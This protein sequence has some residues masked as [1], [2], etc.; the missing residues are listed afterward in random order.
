MTAV[1]LG[2]TSGLHSMKGGFVARLQPGAMLGEYVVG[3]ALWQLR[4][5]EAYRGN[6][7]KG[8][9]TI[10]VIHPQYAA[11]ATIRAHIVAGTRAAA[12]LP[13]HKHLVKTL[14]AG[15]TGDILWI[16]TEEVDGSLVRDL[17]AKKRSA[18]TSGFGAR[19]T[20]NLIAGVSAALAD[21]PHGALSTE[22]VA[23][24]RSGRVRVLDLA[25]AQGT[26]AAILTGAMPVTQH[27]YIAPEILAGGTPDGRADVYGIG[28]LLYEAL[29]GRPFEKG[30]P[31]PSEAVPNLSTQIDEIMLRSCIKDPEKRFS[32]TDVLGEVVSEALTKGG[33][34]QTSMVPKVLEESVPLEAQVSSLAAEI[35]TQS[36]AP[37]AS[38]N[39]VVDRALAAALADGAE[40]W[41][42][43]KGKMDYGP[44]SLAD[45]VKQIN[46]GDIV[47]GNIIVDK[48]D[49]ARVAVDKH[50]LL[51]PLV[52]TAKQK[53]D[54]ARRAQAEVVEQSRAK[55]RGATLYIVI[56]LVVAAVAVG[57]VLIVKNVSKEE[58][59]KI[60]TVTA[61]D[62]AQLEVKI[63]VPKAPPKKQRTAGGGGTAGGGHATS[64]GGG[65]KNSSDALALDMS[66][67]DEDSSATLDMTTVYRVYSGSANALAQCLAN[68]GGGAASIEIIINGPTGRVNFVRVN[69][70]TGGGLQGCIGGVMA[71]LQFPK[72]SGGRTRAEFDMAI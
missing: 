37:T 69:G 59:V 35:G 62:G 23:V 1:D 11:D 6:G 61:S 29:V 48:D 67:D 70:K 72:L 57:V 71:R 65:F 27:G 10:Y 64:G 26:V 14:A 60:A 33:A 38:G 36:L 50:P 19:G 2:A 15:L 56:G 55:K 58:G 41:L 68:N 5:A 47:A 24:S 53:R 63:S 7:P 54:D 30:G 21:L 4:L 3:D 44:F 31:R 17:L 51:G 52:E 25:L 28:L 66:G 34:V 22:S 18:G 32:R 43:S 40:K 13:E 49:G 12:A 42:V 8:P 20:G 9:A 39:L 16:A 46:K 45:V